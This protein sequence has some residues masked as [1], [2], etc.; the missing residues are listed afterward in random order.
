MK[1]LLL[2][3]IAACDTRAPVE[4]C[5]DSLEGEWDHEGHRWVLVESP[6]RVEGYP[7]FA[8]HP[9]T[10]TAGV[11]TA[12]RALDLPRTPSG[13]APGTI[14]RRY[15]LGAHA[16]VATAEVHVVACAGNTLELVI[17]DPAEPVFVDDT[18]CNALRGESHRERWTRVR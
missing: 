11:T 5:T 17:G 2:L 14:A 9:T 3:V 16:C 13:L 8:D 15:Q 10:P 12:P 7:M 4:T 18:R 1:L 6:G